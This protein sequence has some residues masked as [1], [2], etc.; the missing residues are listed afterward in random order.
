MTFERANRFLLLSEDITLI[1]IKSEFFVETSG[2]VFYFRVSQKCLGKIFWQK[3]K[4]GLQNCLPK[5][6]AAAEFS[7]PAKMICCCFLRER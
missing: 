4:N 5:R 2:E 6:A 3:Q 1:E 7:F